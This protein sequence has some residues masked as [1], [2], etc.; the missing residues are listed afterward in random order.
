MIHFGQEKGQTLEI[1]GF[2]P[3]LCEIDAWK[4]QK[5]LDSHVCTQH[6]NNKAIFLQVFLF[7]SH[8]QSCLHKDKEIG[9][10]QT[11][12]TQFPPSHITSVQE[13]CFKESAECT[14]IAFKYNTATTKESGANCLCWLCP[15][16]A[17]LKCLQLTANG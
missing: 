16:G 3:G 5:I 13:Q 6:N 10:L 14:E 7:N 2:L 9:H 15:N 12:K 11:N 1:C 4:L 17:S 8:F